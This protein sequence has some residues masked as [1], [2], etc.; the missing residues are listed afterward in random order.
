MFCA[1][2]VRG[3]G[4]SMSR[5]IARH[6]GSM[7]AVRA[8][9]AEAIEAVE[10]IGPEKSPVVVAELV[11]LAPLIEKL[12][13]AGVTMTEPGWRPPAAPDTGVDPDARTAPEA[14][15]TSELPLAGMPVVV[16]GSMSGALEAL[17]RN[18]MN[19]LIERAGG[20]SSS[21]VSAKMSLLVAGEKAGSKR[22]KAE[23]LGVRIVGPFI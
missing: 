6:F 15:G 12:V 19:E 17:T 21:G 23:G 3:T 8:A 2:G 16:T 11:E 13:A 7:D 18:Q 1:L 20:R 10:G 14:G 22:A 9:D 5:R 4:R